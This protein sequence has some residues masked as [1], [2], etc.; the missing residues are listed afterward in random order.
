MH[1]HGALAQGLELKTQTKDLVASGAPR[2]A[3]LQ[4]LPP[5]SGTEGLD[6]DSTALEDKYNKA[7]TRYTALHR[8]YA[9]SAAQ[10]PHAARVVETHDGEYAYV[11][12][13]GVLHKYSVKSW[14]HRGSTC[15]TPKDVLSSDDEHR[16]SPGSGMPMHHPCGVEGRI[17]RNTKTGQKAW[18]DMDGVKHVLPGDRKTSHACKKDEEDAEDLTPE[19]FDAIRAGPPLTPAGQCTTEAR[20]ARGAELKKLNGELIEMAQ[21]LQSQLKEARGREGRSRGEMKAQEA[22]VAGHVRALQAD[23]EGA[24]GL[25]AA[26][27]G[28][29]TAAAKSA[30]THQL[31]VSRH[32]HYAV[33]LLTA[34]VVVLI[35][36]R[37]VVSAEPHAAATLVALA[38]AL[39]VLYHVVRWLYDKALH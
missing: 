22:A 34:V 9:E 18:V 4:A 31:V 16:L 12:G 25:D 26:E 19:E 28:L 24:G 11:T 39:V 10:R 32:M 6:G 7:L 14:D 36:A 30:S 35:L 20:K 8:E 1:G 38:V 21:K 23:A 13:A 37:A 2:F 3:Q 27:A 33:W 5:L 15:K 29:Q 17:V